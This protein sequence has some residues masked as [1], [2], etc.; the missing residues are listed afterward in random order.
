MMKN[1]SFRGRGIAYRDAMSGLK[2]RQPVRESLLS[3]IVCQLS[4]LH[5]VI[6]NK[7]VLFADESIFPV[8]EASAG[9]HHPCL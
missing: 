1:T 6:I 2:C 5:D 8:R 7:G 4:R 9:W 3:D